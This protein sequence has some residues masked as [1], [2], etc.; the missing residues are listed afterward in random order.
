[1][2]E[3]ARMRRF[4]GPGCTTRWA[5]VL[6]VMTFAAIAAGCAG[7]RVSRDGVP[8]R[9]FAAEPGR[10]DAPED[11]SRVSVPPTT[12]AIACACPVS[13]PG[14]AAPPPSTSSAPTAPC[15][16]PPNESSHAACFVDRWGK[17]K[18]CFAF[19]LTI[20]VWIPGVSGTFGK[21]DTRVHLD[22]PEDGL[23][24]D[25]P[26]VVS[27][28]EF[29]FVGRAEARI[30]RTILFADTFGVSYNSTADFR[31]NGADAEGSLE[32]IIGRVLVGRRVHEGCHDPCRTSV[33][34]DAFVGTRMY[35]VNA[36]L[37]KPDALAFKEDRFWAD[38][39]VAG[40]CIVDLPGRVD[41]TAMADVGGLSVGS[42]LTWSISVGAEWHV[43]Q[44]VDIVLGYTWLA[45]D[46][47]AGRN[48]L[49]VDVQLAGPEL[50]VTI[51]F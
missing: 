5:R 12:A 25:G 16:A 46:Q 30:R 36:E 6:F 19:D 38:P 24:S 3:S 17:P 40:R 45:T 39:I 41:L 49:Q 26:D 9:A 7:T 27:E 50:G 47:D 42:R 20:P 4:P 1:M 31:V 21:G 34:V 13:G 32:A 14:A 2:G 51:H 22:R 23:L 29:A 28:F 48:D 43:S 10:Q 11:A 35:Y 18:P 8:P 33:D 37:K 15:C 44:R